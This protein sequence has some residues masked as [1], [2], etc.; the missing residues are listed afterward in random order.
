MIKNF[1][2]L[3]LAAIILVI[4]TGCNTLEPIQIGSAQLKKDTEKRLELINGKYKLA[5]PDSIEIYVN[6]N[7]ELTTT[8]VIRPD[9]NIFIPLL[10]DVY[11]EGLTPLEVR[12][13]LHKLLS[14]FLRDIPEEAIAVGVLEFN[15]KKVFVYGYDSGITEVPFSG[16]LTVLDAISQSGLLT[17]LSN[18]KKIRIIRGESDP[19]KKPKE[20][21]LNL[22]DI[23]KRGS[24]G[25]NIILRPNDIVYIPPKITAR[26]GLALQGILM[27]VQP[28]E[29]IGSTAYR[30]QY[31][32]AGFA[33]GRGGG[34]SFSRSSGSSDRSR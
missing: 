4:Y 27:P 25:K 2:I 32:A 19:N 29:Q 8:A 34:G 10:G 31:G 26:I 1:M 30:A 15:S 6:D 18:E 24:T 28:V 5:P 23:T 9:G 22:A 3:F 20:L 33:G 11:V 17:R 12:G 21:V 7:P 14:K 16:D 13:K